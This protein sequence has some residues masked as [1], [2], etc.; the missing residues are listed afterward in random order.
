MKRRCEGEASYI[1]RRTASRVAK[2]LRKRE[3]REFNPYR[4]SIC[5]WYHLERGRFVEREEYGRRCIHLK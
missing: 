3:G 5:L 1:D 4:C 2:E